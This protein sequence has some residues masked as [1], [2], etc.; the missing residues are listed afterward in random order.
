MMKEKIVV[1]RK[2]RFYETRYSVGIYI[3]NEFIVN[4]IKN[5][6]Q[7]I[8]LSPGKHL[9]K[10]EQGNRSGE[11]EIDVKKGKVLTCNFSCTP[12]RFFI[13]I[14]L[15]GAYILSNGFEPQGG[16][17]LLIYLPT[18]LITIY[19]FTKGKST[20]FVFEKPT[21]DDTWMTQ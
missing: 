17:I 15:I 2:R 14:T 3:D 8:E 5:N 11:I 13:F 18:I 7:E 20:Y 16:E 4:T 1:E 9:L 10:V 6:R 19:T 12:L 21:E